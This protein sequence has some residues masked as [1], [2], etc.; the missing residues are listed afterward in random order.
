[1]MNVFDYLFDSNK[2]FEKDFLLGSKETV[3]F[4]KLYND[5]LKIASYLK[6]T[7]GE[8][9]NVLLISPNS[10]FFLTAYFGIL[11]SGNTCILRRLDTSASDPRR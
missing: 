10:V 3:S 6:Q 11:K 4:N 8:G 9:Q 5:S 7:I 2:D 1:M